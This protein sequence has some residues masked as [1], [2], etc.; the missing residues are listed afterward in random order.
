MNG[1]IVAGVGEARVMI[2]ARSKDILIAYPIV[3]EAKARELA[4][5]AERARLT[6]S[7]DSAEAIEVISRQVAER[8]V[9]IGIFWKWM[10]GFIAEACPIARLRSDWHSRCSRRRLSSSAVLCF[11]PGCMLAERSRQ[12][13]L[14]VRGNE[15]L[16]RSQLALRQ[17]GI[18]VP[19][20]SGGST[21]TAYPSTEFHEGH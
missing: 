1:I 16:D 21:P 9:R 6:V 11:T 14:L 7:L 8:G 10:S 12:R 13:E 17:A 15:I 3:T 19:E 2:D 18:S 5:L 4:T 20:I